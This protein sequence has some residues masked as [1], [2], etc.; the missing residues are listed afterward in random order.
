MPLMSPHDPHRRRLDLSLTQVVAGALAAVSAAWAAS[1]LGVAGTIIGA[2]V[3]STT[4][5]V[6]SAVYQHGARRTAER[7]RTLRK[8]EM[9]AR[10]QQAAGATAQDRPV[11]P[12]PE[13]ARKP[14]PEPEPVPLDLDRTLVL[15]ALDLEDERGYRWGR[16]A[17]LSLGVF[18]LAMATVT[19]VELATG[20]TLACSAFGHDC[21]QRTSV[22][23]G[24][25]ARPAP[26]PTPSTSVSPS[27]TPSTSVSPTASSTASATPSASDSASPTASPTGSPVASPSATD[28]LGPAAPTPSSSPSTATVPSA[29]PTP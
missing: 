17:L 3:V 25:P 23:P 16:I 19:V 5:S 24:V 4:I 11:A 7:L 9:E 6:L 29:T 18:L 20:H 15:P 27:P 12:V 10:R 28:S 2:A 13:P 1:A 8:A 21:E 14:A 22:T 26:S